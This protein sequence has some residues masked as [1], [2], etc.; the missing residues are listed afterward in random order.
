MVSDY[1]KTKQKL[2]RQFLKKTL[3]ISLA[4]PCRSECCIV[5]NNQRL[6]KVPGQITMW[7]C[8]QL[9]FWLTQTRYSSSYLGGQWESL[10]TQG[11]SENSIPDPRQGAGKPSCAKGCKY[12][13]VKSS[14]KGKA[15]SHAVLLQLQWLVIDNLLLYPVSEWQFLTGMCVWEK[16]STCRVQCYL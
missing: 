5:A 1:F 6:E 2:Q 3:H 10:F 11:S 8:L 15:H 14:P 7:F 9:W 13:T 12:S 4:N 16:Y